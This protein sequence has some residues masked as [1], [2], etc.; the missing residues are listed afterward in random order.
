MEWDKHSAMSNFREIRTQRLL[1]MRGVPNYRLHT[2]S[3]KDTIHCSY[4]CHILQQCSFSSTVSHP[5]DLYLFPNMKI[6]EQ[7]KRAQIYWWWER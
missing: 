3:Q 4:L 1:E 6:E 7:K 2:A 5:S